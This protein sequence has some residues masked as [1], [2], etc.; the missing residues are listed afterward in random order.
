M[1][2]ERRRLLRHGF[3]V[4]MFALLLGFPVALGPHN[5]A[6]MA[7]HV[8]A[9]IGSLL[10]LA[11]AQV[12]TEL[13]LRD[14]QRKVAFV[15]LLLGTYANL[16]ANVFRAMVDLPGPATRPGIPYPQWQFAVFALLSA[17]LVPS[18]LTAVALVL[19][20]LRGSSRP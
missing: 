10:V 15:A 8:T 18:L 2:S 1:E 5:R 7:A 4:M 11:V 12:W 9:F 17:V 20:G 19:M 13:R 14:S 3:A 16:A 6:W